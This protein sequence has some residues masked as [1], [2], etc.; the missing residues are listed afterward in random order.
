[1]NW[2]GSAALHVAG[3]EG[4]VAAGEEAAEAGWGQHTRGLA[5]W[6]L[7]GCSGELERHHEGTWPTE[8]ARLGF[9]TPSVSRPQMQPSVAED[10]DT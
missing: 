6:E 8:K 5:G 3:T 10:A 9:G 7:W 4:Q 2:V 1:M